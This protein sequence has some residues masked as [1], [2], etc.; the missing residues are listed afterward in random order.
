MVNDDQHD[1][2]QGTSQAVGEPQVPVPPYDDLRG[3]PAENTAPTA[4]DASNAPPRGPD[5]PVSEEER[6]GMSSTDMD[7][8]P[9]LGVGE[10]RG[11]RAEDLAPDRDDVGTKGPSGRPFGRAAEDEVDDSGPTDSPALQSG[12]QGG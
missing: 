8:E 11:G 12:D 3:E 1:L 9:P 4:F 7:P 6:A 2:E 5:V 10:S